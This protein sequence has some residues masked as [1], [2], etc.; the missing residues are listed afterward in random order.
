MDNSNLNGANQ[1]II[2]T[3]QIKKDVESRITAATDSRVS[4]SS[5]VSSEDSAQNSESGLS[6]FEPKLE[7]EAP[8]SEIIKIPETSSEVNPVIPTESS[9]TTKKSRIYESRLFGRHH[10]IKKSEKQKHDGKI[11]R[12]IKNIIPGHISKRFIGER[13]SRA[14][15]ESAVAESSNHNTEIEK[16][17]HK[18]NGAFTRL[19]GSAK[20]KP[21]HL[22]ASL[23]SNADY[24]EQSTGTKIKGLIKNEAH[25]AIYGESIL[26]KSESKKPVIKTFV[27]KIL[28]GAVGIAKIIVNTY[29]KIATFTLPPLTSAEALITAI[30]GASTVT[31][32]TTTSLVLLIGGG[33]LGLAVVVGLIYLIHKSPELAKDI[34][35]KSALKPM[36]FWQKRALNALSIFL[37]IHGMFVEKNELQKYYVAVPDED[38]RNFVAQEGSI[39][40]FTSED[41]IKRITRIDTVKK[42]L[43]IGLNLYAFLGIAVTIVSIFFPAAIPG[44]LAFMVFPSMLGKVVYI[45]S[46]VITTILFLKQTFYPSRLERA[47]KLLKSYGKKKFQGLKSSDKIKLQAAS[48]ITLAAL[49]KSLT[50]RVWS[51]KQLQDITMVNARELLGLSRNEREGYNTLRGFFKQNDALLT[52]LRPRLVRLEKEINKFEEY[53]VDF[54]QSISDRSETEKVLEDLNK[55]ANRK[56]LDVLLDAFLDFCTMLQ[57]E[58]LTMEDIRKEMVQESMS[59]RDAVIRSFVSGR[60]SNRTTELNDDL[61]KTILEDSIYA[62]PNEEVRHII[63]AI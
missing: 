8:K 12:F 6:F 60:M 42:V 16:N 38:K 3:S 24:L 47:M 20:H 56:E 45:A 37:I 55:Q 46:V 40:V 17:P 63:E 36:T 19:F 2:T 23:L 62:S 25:K 22:T 30:I 52:V 7:V 59:D 33:V 44:V 4:S 58:N 21:R 57:S 15:P 39:I 29:T 14:V 1:S 35:K 54:R 49:C 41:F 43:N 31:F 51:E 28:F 53:D 5:N 9:V 11:K 48:I 13:L 50:G 26:I 34:A 10:E 27:D 32:I 18:G 61:K